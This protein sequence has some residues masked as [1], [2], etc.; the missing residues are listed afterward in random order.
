[1]Q[2]AIPESVLQNRFYRTK[3]EA[4]YNESEQRRQWKIPVCGEQQS[5][6]CYLQGC[7]IRCAM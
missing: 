3:C 1:M 7:Y 4:G 5:W 2:V 6:K